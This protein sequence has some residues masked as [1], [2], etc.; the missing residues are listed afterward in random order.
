MCAKYIKFV[1]QN[2]FLYLFLSRKGKPL[3]GPS[4]FCL[5]AHASCP[6]AP[7][8]RVPLQ[9]FAGTPVGGGPPR[10]RT[11]LGRFLLSAEWPGHVTGSLGWERTLGKGPPWSRAN[12]LHAQAPKRER[13]SQQNSQTAAK[14]SENIQSAKDERGALGMG[15]PQRGRRPSLRHHGF[16]S[17]CSS[18]ACHCMFIHSPPSL[19][20][21]LHCPL[22]L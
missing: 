21:C 12:G 7:H 15:R 14:S 9:S 5:S 8:D 3:G 6:Y 19:A 22:F 1:F 16:P 11:G 4:S 18:A 13:A 2:N 17:P 10:D 20:Y